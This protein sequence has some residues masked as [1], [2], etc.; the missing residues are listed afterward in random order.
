MNRFGFLTAVLATAIVGVA[1]NTEVPDNKLPTKIDSVQSAVGEIN[2]NTHNAVFLSKGHVASTDWQNEFLVNGN[3]LY[4]LRSHGVDTII[5][6]VADTYG[7]GSLRGPATQIPNFLA[8]I[9]SWENQVT[10]YHFTVYAWVNGRTESGNTY[11]LRIDRPATRTTLANESLKF[12]SSTVAGNFTSTMLGLERAFDGVF[13]DIEESGIHGTGCPELL[14]NP[15][16][17]DCLKLTLQAVRNVLNPNNQGGMP[18]V[19]VAGAKRAPNTNTPYSNGNWWTDSEYYY[20]G[21][22]SDLVVN[23]TYDTN[24][25]N[26]VP[27]AGVNCNSNDYEA[28]MRGEVTY[29]SKALSGEVWSWDVNH[30][31]PDHNVQLM[32]AFPAFPAKA[33]HNITIEN[34][35]HASNGTVLGV[36]D[37]V[38]QNSQSRF[39]F[40]GAAMYAQATGECCDPV[41]NNCSGYTFYDPY[42]ACYANTL[43]WNY[44]VSNWMS[45]ASW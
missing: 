32:L 16:R 7:N 23:M 2:Y 21:R 31:Y 25:A 11:R 29:A 35:E 4:D 9:R 17:F 44:W 26:C 30:P 36:S 27:S 5:V 12:V 33:A 39:F 15:S 1:C 38:A 40:A 22:Y 28:W 43:D 42:P 10:D 6:N 37:M 41:V 19:G 8:A 18:K 3:L 13:L 45:L 34:V 20:A 14:G 24:Q